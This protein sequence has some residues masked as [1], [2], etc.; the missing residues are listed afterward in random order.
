MLVAKTGQI[1]AFYLPAKI[2][3][4]TLGKVVPVR[5]FTTEAAKKN[6]MCGNGVIHTYRYLFMSF[7]TTRLEPFAVAPFRFHPLPASGDSYG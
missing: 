3:F 2:G 1:N 5:G 7:D 6:P 4:A